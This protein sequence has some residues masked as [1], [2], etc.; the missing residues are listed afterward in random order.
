MTAVA[1]TEAPT[2]IDAEGYAVIE[3]KL[4][5]INP[6]DVFA[7]DRDPIAAW[8]FVL[9]DMRGITP[10]QRHFLLR[11]IIATRIS[12]GGKY[13]KQLGE[14]LLADVLAGKFEPSNNT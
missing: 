14:S 6:F 1:T 10:A 8:K 11:T 9:N 7:V 4:S 13:D 5:H 12:Q 3:Q 2:D